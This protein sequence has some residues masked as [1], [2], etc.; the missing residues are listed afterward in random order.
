M[1]FKEM[2][3]PLVSK[4]IDVSRNKTW[5]GEK[6]PR[7]WASVNAPAVHRP[8]GGTGAEEKQQKRGTVGR[9]CPPW[10]PIAERFVSQKTPEGGG[11]S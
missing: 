1:Y 8:H 10:L 6:S 5:E 2:L 11:S 3:N 9:V 7:G 4:A